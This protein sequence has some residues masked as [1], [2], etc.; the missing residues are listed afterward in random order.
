MSFTSGKPSF[1]K[2]EPVK[3]TFGTSGLRGLVVDMTDL[4]CYINTK[5]FLEY[6]KG[7]NNISAGDTICIAGDLRSS[8]GR[9]MAAVTSAIEDSG[10]KVDNC[11]LIPTPAMA[12]YAMQKG[13]ASIMVTGSHIPDDRNGIKFYKRGG[14]VLKADEDGI[15]AEVTRVRKEEYARSVDETLFD[16][17]GMFKQ[18]RNTGP[19]NEEAKEAY[20]RRY[21]DVYPG[22]Y[23]S[24]KTIIVY[25]QSAVSRDILTYVLENLGA[26]VIPVERSDKFIAIDTEN[27][28][29]QERELFRLFIKK[30]KQRH[31]FAVVSTDG[32]GDRPFVAD[33]RGE[34]HRGD[35]VGVIVCHY[36]NAR[37][38]AVPISANDSVA[39]QLAKNGVK[40]RHT[41]IGSPY[42]IEAMNE[43]IA[44]GKS[45][46]VSW[47][48]NGGFLTGTDFSINGKTLKALPT[49]DGLLPGLCVLAQATKKDT[50]VSE[51]FAELP[52]RYT[53]AGV[54]DNF[55][56]DIGRKI[57][58]HFS[59]PEESNVER[60]SF[61]A[62]A[63]RV[64]DFADRDRIL[65][66]ESPIFKVI[67]S[68]KTELERFFNSKLGFDSITGINYLDGV[69]VTFAN[70]DV[71]HLRPS[72]NAPQF[73]VYSNANSQERATE[74][75]R[76]S[77][78][79]VKEYYPVDK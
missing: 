42:V 45:S 54:I 38:A 16:E 20:I 50:A 58:K 32:D 72:G 9:I 46:V 6:V 13:R 40:L 67:S 33:E 41:K 44:Q 7:I 39:I 21:L 66:S 78:A 11:G 5:G 49:R 28:T 69:K 36:L 75:V 60:V 3:L 65:D 59:L 68:N 62:G 14:E 51:L 22:D 4:E 52:R 26:E 23:F 63:V 34:L 2:K 31:P 17:R 18:P 70:G 37:F 74:I 57:I 30:H 77:L 10:C 76:L 27:M 73:R 47:E 79:K 56:R 64:T 48:V 53:D 19:V 24:G 25:Q 61:E 35:V 15:T 71:A 29:P 8:T 43:A 1:L 12:Y 55:P